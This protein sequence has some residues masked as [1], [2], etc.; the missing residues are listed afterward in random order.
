MCLVSC[1]DH[2]I[3]AAGHT[4]PVV[5][6]AFS[7]IT[8]DGFFL[9]S[10]CKDGKPILRNGASIHLLVGRPSVRCLSYKRGHGETKRR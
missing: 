8:D 7:P 2:S 1:A 5:D 9:I 10:A 6:L 4:R 3:F